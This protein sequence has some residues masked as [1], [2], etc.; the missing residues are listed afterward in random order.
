MIRRIGAS[1]WLGLCAA[2]ANI[3]PPPGGPPD[4]APPQLVSISPESLAVLPA[5]D[6]D[7][8]FRFSEVVAE[9]AAGQGDALGE[10][11]RLVILSPARGVPEI[12]WHRN[13]ITV[14]PRGGWLPNRV[15]RV[16]LDA[17]RR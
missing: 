14:R 4:T 6:G 5:F 9:G 16:Q 2:C 15:Y 10:L 8:E 3:L 17:S 1:G 12:R 11:E 13:R 7:V